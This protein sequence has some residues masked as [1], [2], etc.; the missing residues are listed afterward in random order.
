M[1]APTERERIVLIALSRLPKPVRAGQ[2]MPAQDCNF[3][4]AADILEGAALK[5]YVDFRWPKKGGKLWQINAAGLA[6]INT[7]TLATP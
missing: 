2:I 7:P 5:G 3:R 1:T 6:A 4:T